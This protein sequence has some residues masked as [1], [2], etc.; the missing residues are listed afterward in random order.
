VALS[1]SA[2]CKWKYVVRVVEIPPGVYLLETGLLFTD[3]QGAQIFSVCMCEERS[4]Q[5]PFSFSALRTAQPQISDRNIPT[6]RKS[7]K[8]ARYQDIL[9]NLPTVSRKVTSNC[10][11]SKGILPQ[12]KLKYRRANKHCGACMMVSSL[13]VNTVFFHPDFKHSSYSGVWWLLNQAVA[14][15]QPLV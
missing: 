4:Y 11:L 2:Q 5:T 13:I 6:G 7:Y 12:H 9:T 14:A 1:V 15:L 3:L 8:R 10:R